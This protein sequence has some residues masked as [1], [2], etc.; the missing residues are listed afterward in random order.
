MA[1][2]QWRST[3]WNPFNKSNHNAK[4]KNLRPVTRWMCEQAANISVGMRI[5]DSCRKAL[6]RTPPCLPEVESQPSV[7]PEQESSSQ[8]GSPRRQSPPCSEEHQFEASYLIIPWPSQNQTN[9]IST[10]IPNLYVHKIILKSKDPF[11]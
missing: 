8:S 2:S 3:C 1:Q 9:S 11:Y 5:C 4:R 10:S 7:L 6:T